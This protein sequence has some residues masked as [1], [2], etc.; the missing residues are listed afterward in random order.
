MNKKHLIIGG[1]AVA[2]IGL[3]LYAR[4]DSGASSTNAL[5]KKLRANLPAS[6]MTK[7]AGVAPTSSATTDDSQSVRASEVE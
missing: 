3:V 5:V 4:S 2:A 6:W 1:V 7:T